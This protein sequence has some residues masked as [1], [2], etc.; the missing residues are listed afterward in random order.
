MPM[1]MLVNSAP[2]DARTVM[3]LGM[4]VQNP[5]KKMM[6]VTKIEGIQDLVLLDIHSPM[7]M[8]TTT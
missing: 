1:A 7:K 3:S 2:K 8:A 4:T 5:I 6:A